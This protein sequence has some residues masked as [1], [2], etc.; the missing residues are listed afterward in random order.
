M[1]LWMEISKILEDVDE[2]EASYCMNEKYIIDPLTIHFIRVKDIISVEKTATQVV[3]L[4]DKK[5]FVL[6]DPNSDDLYKR[7]LEVWKR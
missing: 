2:M 5:K 3:L 1:S 4:G 6:F 7:V